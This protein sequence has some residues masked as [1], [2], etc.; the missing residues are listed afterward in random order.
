M[1]GWWSVEEGTN[2]TVAES[3]STMSSQEAVKSGSHTVD[4]ATQRQI[5]ALLRLSKEKVEAGDG[6]G[7]IQAAL[8]AATLSS[9]GDEQAV[10]RCLDA[11]KTKAESGRTAA[12]RRG[13]QNEE[14][15]AQ[16]AAAATICEDM[17]RRTSILKDE[18]DEEI[19]RDAMEDGSSVVCVRCGGL[20][21]RTRWDAHRDMWCPKWEASGDIEDAT[22]EDLV[23]HLD[24]CKRPKIPSEFL[25]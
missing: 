24:R 25:T 15:A 14:E 10:F 20:V 11:A 19:L 1:G 12:Y 23:D 21:A 8:Q 16:M 4:A 18:G 9:G 3:A 7:A 5:E 13:A 22:M 6:Q 2:Q 17:L